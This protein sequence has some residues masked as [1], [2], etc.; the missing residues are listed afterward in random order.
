MI[1]V[2][3]QM[4]TFSSIIYHHSK[5]VVLV[6]MNSLCVDV[7][8]TFLYFYGSL[9]FIMFALYVLHGRISDKSIV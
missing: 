4:S 5:N 6:Y 1:N 8:L 7:N 2:C 3:I 9:T